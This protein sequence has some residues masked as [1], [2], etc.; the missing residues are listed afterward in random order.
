M[1][2]PNLECWRKY[3][4]GYYLVLK[5]KSFIALLRGTTSWNTDRTKTLYTFHLPVF[6]VLNIFIDTNW[7]WSFSAFWPRRCWTLRAAPWTSPESSLSCSSH[8]FRPLLSAA[9]PTHQ[10]GQNPLP[11]FFLVC[12]LKADQLSYSQT[13]KYSNARFARLFDT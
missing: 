2:A 6:T 9:H 8:L 4:E 12:T 3:I 7:W 11:S 10:G 5:I 13:D 1:D